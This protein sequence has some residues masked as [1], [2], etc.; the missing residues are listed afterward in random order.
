MRIVGDRHLK[1][2]LRVEAGAVHTGALPIEAIAFGYL[3]G[4]A[5]DPQLVPGSALQLA[6]RLEI[7]EYRGIE[8]MQLNCQH[9]VRV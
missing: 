8:R 4:S 7:N 6:Y 9:L 2:N 1:M 5:E 3:G